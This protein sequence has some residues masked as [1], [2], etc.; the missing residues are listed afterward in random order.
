MFQAMRPG[1]GKRVRFRRVSHVNEL[2]NLFYAARRRRRPEPAAATNV[3][4]TSVADSG[5]AADR[6]SVV[7]NAAPIS[8]PIEAL[9]LAAP[10]IIPCLIAAEI[11]TP[12]DV[13]GGIDYAVVVVVSR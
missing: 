9:K 1:C 13:I 6:G 10:Y 8:G 12:I 3:N 5:T 2:L 11:L 7:G 4:N